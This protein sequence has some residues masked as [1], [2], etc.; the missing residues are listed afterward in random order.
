MRTRIPVL[1]VVTAIAL[2]ATASPAVAQPSPFPDGPETPA[3]EPVHPTLAEAAVEWMAAR[4]ATIA[5][6][7]TTP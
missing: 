1:S 3:R 5:R 4:I 6:G 2:L 7:G